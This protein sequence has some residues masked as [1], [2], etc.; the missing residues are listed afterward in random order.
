MKIAFVV[1][2]CGKD[3]FGGAEALTLQI[4]LQ[5][6]I[7]FQVE[8]LT[9]R[10]KDATTWKNHYPEGVEKLGNLVIRRFPV[11]KERDPNF[12]P[13]SQYLELNNDDLEKG[14][15]FLQASGPVCTTLLKYV[16]DNSDKYDLFI[17][18]GYLYWQ[19]YHGL[20]L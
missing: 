20:P 13:L 4:G 7:F 3:V 2:R 8:I 16:Q 1:Q 14:N 9:T 15:D 19:T 17:F 12:V 10:A 5:L 11:D 18:V 6:S